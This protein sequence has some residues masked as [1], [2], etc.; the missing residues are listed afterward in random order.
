MLWLI[1]YALL[2]GLHLMQAGELPG[3]ES[4]ATQ[5]VAVLHRDIKPSNS[6]CRNDIIEEN[7]TLTSSQCFLQRQTPTIGMAFR[8]SRYCNLT[9]NR[10]FIG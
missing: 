7:S 4:L 5:A 10:F 1:L 3:L 9:D 2:T 6:E 8:F